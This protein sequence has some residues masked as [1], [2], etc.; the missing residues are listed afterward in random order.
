MDLQLSDESF[1]VVCD[2]AQMEQVL[3]SLCFNARDAM[4]GTGNLLVSLDSYHSENERCFICSE[5]LQGEWV[6][7]LV[8]DNGKGIAASDLE[9]IF[10]PYYTTKVGEKDAGMGLSVVKGIVASYNGH[11]LVKTEQGEGSQFYILMPLCETSREQCESEVSEQSQEG[12]ESSVNNVQILVVD[13][14]SAMRQ[15]LKETLEEDGVEVSACANGS[16]A[17]NH[18]QQSDYGCDLL[19]TDQEMPHM[20]GLEL[21]QL[22]RDEDVSIPVVLCKGYSDNIKRSLLDDLHIDHCLVKPLSLQ[23]LKKIVGSLLSPDS[24]ES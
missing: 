16:E 19:I 12:S 3:L 7:L 8:Q 23:E 10:E 18:L 21:V 5:R 1:R 15:L 24:K 22:L 17:W 2:P 13:G 9:H 14:E 11:I 4:D 20:T 6:S